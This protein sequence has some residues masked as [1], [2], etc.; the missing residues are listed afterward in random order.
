MSIDAQIDYGLTLSYDCC[1]FFLK[2]GIDIWNGVSFLKKF[3]DSCL[4]YFFKLIPKV[5]V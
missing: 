1:K 4:N 2:K 5:Q 3:S